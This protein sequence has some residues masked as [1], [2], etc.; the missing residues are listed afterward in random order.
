MAAKWLELLKEVVSTLKRVGVVRSANTPTGPA[1]FGVIQA[2]APYLKVD[3]SA[4]NIRTADDLET[5]ILVSSAKRKFE[6]CRPKRPVS[7]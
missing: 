3:V 4:L 7:P 2:V 1:Q 5:A 6:P